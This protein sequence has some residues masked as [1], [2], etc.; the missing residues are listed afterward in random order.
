MQV[1]VFLKLLLSLCL[2]IQ[3][4]L[5]GGFL[6][7]TIDGRILVQRSQVGGLSLK[8]DAELEVVV[9]QGHDK[10]AEELRPASYVHGA[11]DGERFEGLHY[12]LRR[13]GVAWGFSTFGIVS[14]RR[15]R[16]VG[17]VGLARY[18]YRLRLYARVNQPVF[19]ALGVEERDGVC[20]LVN[21]IP[22]S[23]CAG[24][25]I[26]EAQLTVFADGPLDGLRAIWRR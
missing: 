8:A 24:S 18:F 10:A 21:L 13:D 17:L 14:F 20:I 4:Q 19:L 11:G 9:L 15:L 2:Y 7:G 5:G 23:G 22:V 6:D 25:N 3:S 12:L 16:S 1:S 26:E